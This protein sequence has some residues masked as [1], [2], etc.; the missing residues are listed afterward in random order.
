VTVNQGGKTSFIAGDQFLS[1]M[2][3]THLVA[4]IEGVPAAVLNAAAQLHYRAF[5]LVALIVNRADLFP[6]NWI[7][8]HTPEVQAGRIQNFKNWSI[9]M[10]PDPSRSGIGVEYFCDEGDEFWRR[11]DGAL[12]ELA[13]RELVQ[14]GLVRPGEVVDGAVYRHS[15]AYPVYAQGY[16]AHLQVVRRFLATIANLQTMGRNGMHRYNNQDHSMLTAMLAVRNLFGESH[17]LWEVNTERSYAE[18]FV[19]TE[20]PAFASA[21]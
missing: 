18:E 14:L 9:A 15:M 3:I 7:Y 17:D 8:I 10:V 19:L 20:R 1:S 13:A 12:I 4:R 16:T 6:D 21:P 11:E 5:V 2:P